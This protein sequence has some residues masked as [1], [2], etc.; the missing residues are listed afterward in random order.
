LR[1]RGLL[2]WP[3]IVAGRAVV[4]ERVGEITPEQ[5]AAEA[6]NWLDHPQ[7]LAGMQED[8]RS[9]RGQPGAVARLAGLIS[10]LLP[11]VPAVQG[12]DAASPLPVWAR[13]LA[14]PAAVVGEVVAG[15]V[16][17]GEVSPECRPQRETRVDE[18]GQRWPGR[19]PEGS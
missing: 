12:A 18:A 9:L 7:R 3:N 14:Q 17:V 13:P 6:A 2:A 11:G 19:E 15:E 1:K 8:L 5:I 16:V 10:E 4:P